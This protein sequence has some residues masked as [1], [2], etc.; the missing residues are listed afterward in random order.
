MLRNFGKFP[1]A[2]RKKSNVLIDSIQER[3]IFAGLAYS[4]VESFFNPAKKIA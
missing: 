3:Y 2:R 1:N 4:G